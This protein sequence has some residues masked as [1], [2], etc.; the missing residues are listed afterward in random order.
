[1][2]RTDDLR[3][4]LTSIFNVDFR[5]RCLKASFSEGKF[6]G[7]PGTIQVALY[8]LL[9][10]SLL[11]REEFKTLSHLSAKRWWDLNE[12]FRLAKGLCLLWSSI[13]GLQNLKGTLS[14]RCNQSVNLKS[15]PPELM[16]SKFN[17]TVSS[18]VLCSHKTITIHLIQ[19]LL[20]L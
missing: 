2:E 14:Y 19:G 4:S 6:R 12:L 1:M 18:S 9:W 13:I 11:F 20:S 7:R 5:F 8:I 16:V 10:I 15:F 3:V 17:F